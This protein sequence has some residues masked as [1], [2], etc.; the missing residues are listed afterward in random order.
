MTAKT[1][2]TILL[3]CGIVLGAFFAYTGCRKL[4]TDWV[5]AKESYLRYHPL[6]V[7][8]ASGVIELIAGIGLMIPVAR[9]TSALVLTAMI[10][11]VAANSWRGDLKHL[12]GPAVIFPAILLV[13]AWF[14]RPAGL[15]TPPPR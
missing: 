2:Q 5:W 15:L 9:F 4:F 8:Y 14:S 7:Y 10:L 12:L 6:W 11:A 1:G 3:I 13:L